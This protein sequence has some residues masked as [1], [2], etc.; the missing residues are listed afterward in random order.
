MPPQC[1][2]VL[3]FWL[4][5]PALF[6]SIPPASPSVS[7]SNHR[8]ETREHTS[9]GAAG[10]IRKRALLA[11]PVAALHVDAEGTGRRLLSDGT[12]CHRRKGRPV[13]NGADDTRGGVAVMEG[14]LERDSGSTANVPSSWVLK[15]SWLTVLWGRIAGPKGGKDEHV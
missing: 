6:L 12:T 5:A 10:A 3:D 4:A 8:N 11:R 13:I 14:L 9:A 15:I 7:G 2:R 1:T